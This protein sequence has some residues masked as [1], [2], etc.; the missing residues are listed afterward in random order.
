MKVLVALIGVAT[1]LCSTGMA[2]QTLSV[3][4]DVEAPFHF[5]ND[6]GKVVG[7]DADLLRET[8]ALIGVTPV[9]KRINWPRTLQGIEAGELDVAIGAKYTDERS[10]FA[11]YSGSYKQI[12]H[13]LYVQKGKHGKVETLRSFLQGG[14][15]LGIMRGFGYPP[16]VAATIGQEGV[17]PKLLA[18]NHV[19]QLPQLLDLGRVDGIVY[20]PQVMA[21]QRANRDFKH[22]FEV[23][24]RYYERLHFLLSKKTVKPELVSRFNAALFKMMVEGRVEAIF[25]R[26]KHSKAE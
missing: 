8:L 11:W 24:A 16:E 18:A 23:R 19:E 26:Y 3:G 17:K 5:T 13:Y 21:D 14:G 15:K 9:F 1:F 10:A 6:E 7:T 12:A 25:Q 22:V 4:Y 20:N 2:A